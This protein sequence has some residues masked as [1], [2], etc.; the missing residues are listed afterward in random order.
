MSMPVW[1]S[2]VAEIDDNLVG[3]I[4]AERQS[5]GYGLP[6]GARIVAI[7]VHPDQRQKGIGRLLL[8]AL[9]D[10]S[11]SRGI[12][13]I[14]SVLMAEDQRDIDFLASCGFD[15]AQVKVLIAQI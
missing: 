11:R 6:P 15:S 12:R 13:Q 10:D 4:L 1:G 14:F 3:F 7:A 8:E 2:F 9:K 5:V